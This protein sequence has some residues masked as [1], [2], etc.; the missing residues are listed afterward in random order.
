MRPC[1]GSQRQGTRT[2]KGVVYG[3]DGGKK[4]KG[5]KRHILVDSQG[6]LIGV[7]VN[8][9][10]A[11]ERH[12]AITV[13]EQVKDKL[14]RTKVVWVD[15]G[16]SGEDFAK[17]IKEICGATVEVVKRNSKEFEVLP[18]RWIVERSFGWLNRY[19]RMSK[20]YE[21]QTEFSEGMIYGAFIRLML[22]RF[23]KIAASDFV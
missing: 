14:V 1:A 17:A 22:R 23:D 13:A 3:F 20:D 5:R 2:K 15:G 16:Y 7:L 18:H 12:G 10:N 9:A 8:E 19:R 6:L 21:Q 11:S 4:V